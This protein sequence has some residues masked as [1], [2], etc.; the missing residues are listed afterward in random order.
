MQHNSRIIQSLDCKKLSSVKEMYELI[1]FDLDNGIYMFDIACK[2]AEALL[3]E[4][5]R[6]YP[7]LREKMVIQIKCGLHLS[8]EFGTKFYDLSYEGIINSVKESLERTNIK[9]ADVLILEKPD[10]FLESDQIARAIS[11]LKEEG[12]VNRFGVANFP[13]EAVK[14]ISDQTN[15]PLGINQLDLN[16]NH[17]NVVNEVLHTNT[18]RN[19]S[20]MTTSELYFYMRRHGFEIQAIQSPQSLD[21][22]DS[23]ISEAL[24]KVA[25]KHNSGLFTILTSFILKLGYNVNVVIKNCTIDEVKECI[26]SSE[27]LLT[28]EEWYY[29]YQAAGYDL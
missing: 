16:I 21:E 28:N 18:E 10:I 9:Y 19:G 17:L 1:S 26:Y 20:A 8:E 12:L 5:L 11:E 23:K 25:K 27:S 22:Y 4:T 13:H 14:Y 29:L 3:G 7:E 15:I 2:K 6:E 24:T